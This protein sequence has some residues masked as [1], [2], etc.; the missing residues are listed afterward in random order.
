[1]YPSQDFFG[2]YKKKMHDN[3]QDI[4]CMFV[5]IYDSCVFIKKM[6]EKKIFNKKYLMFLMCPFRTNYT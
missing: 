2:V 3:D 4:K 5:I 6:K 1:M